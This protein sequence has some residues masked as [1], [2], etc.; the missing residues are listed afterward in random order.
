M[1]LDSN[2]T[3]TLFSGN[4]KVGNN[5][6]VIKVT[7]N[8]FM[9]C[10]PKV[11]G[12]AWVFFFQA[13]ILNRHLTETP[14]IQL[15]RT[16]DSSFQFKVVYFIRAIHYE[17]NKLFSLNLLPAQCPFQ[18]IFLWRKLLHHLHPAQ[19][20]LENKKE[21][22]QPYTKT[23]QAVQKSRCMKQQNIPC[24]VKK[25]LISCIFSIISPTELD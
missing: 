6:I 10:E 21:L 18:H 14:P 25:L 4:D 15:N 5:K 23:M 11:Q 17:Q 19:P 1:F 13:L 7:Y 20:L 3:K 8:L 2:F 22:F 12:K 24:K 9:H 16:Q